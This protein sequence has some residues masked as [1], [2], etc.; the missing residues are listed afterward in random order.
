M[1][2]LAADVQN[3]CHIHGAES[4]CRFNFAS[5]A[6]Q[7]FHCFVIE[8][9]SKSATSDIDLVDPIVLNIFC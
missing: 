5:L 9:I 7:M 6:S 3:L 1:Q 2:G 8:S 4:P